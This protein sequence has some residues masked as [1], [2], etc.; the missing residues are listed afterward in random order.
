[1]PDATIS[2][3]GLRVMKLLV[4]NAPQAVS[5]LI[6]ATGVTRTAVTEQL[7]ELAA[8]GF[9][10][11]A[12]ERLSGR[13][14][15]RHLYKATDAALVALFAS[16]Q[17]LVVPAIWRAIGELG[18]EE[19]VNKVLKLVGRALA[20]HYNGK[21]TAKKPQERLRQFMAL[22][23]AE[24]GLIEAVEDDD[25]QLVL[26]KRSCPFIS[27]VDERRGVCHID[28]EVLNAVVGRPVR[29]TACRHDGAPCCTFEI[30]D[31]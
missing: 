2:A 11:R 24:G 3:A 16:N 26:Y 7:N 8:A 9:V 21:I 6:R 25:G 27:M 14:R 20:D 23:T 12:T 22:L 15:P 5:D 10:E 18:G 1:M 28:Q 4:G 13:G 29:Q 31:Q 17:R 30:V 19:L